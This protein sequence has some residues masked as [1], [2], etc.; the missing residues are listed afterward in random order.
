MTRWV[1]INVQEVVK[2][3]VKDVNEHVL[4]DVAIIVQASVIN[5]VN[6]HVREGAVKIAKE[7]VKGIVWVVVFK[8]A[9]EVVKNL[10][11]MVVVALRDN[12]N[13]RR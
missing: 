6:L 12:E 10:V 8:H 3:A 5:H 4:M 2:V 11:L 1:A 9:K 13:K 7:T